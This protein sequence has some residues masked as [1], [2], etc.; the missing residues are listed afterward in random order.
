MVIQSLQDLGA[1]IVAPGEYESNDLD[2]VM[3]EV[4]RRL[5]ITDIHTSSSSDNVGGVGVGGGLRTPDKK[6]LSLLLSASDPQPSQWTVL[7]YAVR[8]GYIDL[9]SMLIQY[10]A[11]IHHRI[12]RG[13]GASTLYLAELY[14]GSSHPVSQLLSSNGATSLPPALQL[15]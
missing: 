3:D 13:H 7:Q 9:V 10:G 11:N 5:G 6:R 8:S 14:H 12:N 1:I 15:Q 2:N 4:S